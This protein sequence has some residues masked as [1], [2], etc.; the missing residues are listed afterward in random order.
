MSRATDDSEV[1]G[2]GRT[3]SS[4]TVE[5]KIEDARGFAV[6]AIG[7]KRRRGWRRTMLLVVGWSFP[8]VVGLT[9]LAG[10]IAALL[11]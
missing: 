6:G 11:R 10:A 7:A 2:W 5:G 8:V 4:Y 1:G 3:S 9:L